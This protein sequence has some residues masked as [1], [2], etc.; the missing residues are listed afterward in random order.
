MF[1][2]NIIFLLCINGIHDVL[3]S[4]LSND[5]RYCTRENTKRNFTNVDL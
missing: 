1:Y 5:V 3:G 4:F 2:C